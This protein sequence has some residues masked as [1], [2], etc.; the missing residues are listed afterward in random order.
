MTRPARLH[1]LRADRCPQSDDRGAD[2]YSVCRHLLK[3]VHEGSLAAIQ[4]P[5]IFGGPRLAQGVA[6][7][8]A[9]FAVAQRLVQAAMAD[10]CCLRAIGGA[11]TVDGGGAGLRFDLSAHCL[12][13]W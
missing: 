11:A 10:F 13:A 4:P 7:G 5:C 8:R 6:A 2:T 12:R 9:L 1:S 3:P